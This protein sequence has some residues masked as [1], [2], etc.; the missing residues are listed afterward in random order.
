MISASFEPEELDLLPLFN[1]EADEALSLDNSLV[2]LFPSHHIAS[3]P[4]RTIA[5]TAAAILKFML[6]QSKTT[7]RFLFRHRFEY[8]EPTKR[9]C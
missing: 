2:G 9:K 3:P 1:E 4:N 6:D 8:R 5:N 7:R